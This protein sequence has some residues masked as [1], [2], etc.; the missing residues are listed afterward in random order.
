MQQ[1]STILQM[2]NRTSLEA[3]TSLRSSFFQTT[4]LGVYQTTPDGKIVAA[5]DA[6]INMLGYKSFEDLAD[7]NLN[8]Q[9]L[10][11]MYPRSQFIQMLEAQEEIVGLEYE[12]KKKDGTTLY[13]R[14]NARVIRN[15]DA[16][17]YYE[18][19]I[20]D[21]TDRKKG[22]VEITESKR[23]LQAEI[24]R[25]K[26][27]ANNLRQRAKQQRI[28]A[29]F[30]QRILISTNSTHIIDDALST[31][32]KAL[33][34]KHATYKQYLKK[35][36]KVIIANV[37]GF[38]KNVVDTVKLSV[39]KNSLSGYTLLSNAPVI[40]KDLAQEK[41]FHPPS[42]LADAKITSAMTVI[43]QSGKKIFG[44]LGVY[45]IN[46]RTFTRNDI[47]FIQ[48]IA[49]SLA[50]AMERDRID[51]ALR[52]SEERFRSI[53]DNALDPILI[54]DNKGRIS[55]ANQAL[56][57]L[58]GMDRDMLFSQSFTDLIIP[59]KKTKTVSKWKQFMQSGRQRGEAMIQR[60]DGTTRNIEYAAV[61][62]I[63]P[64][65]HLAMVRDITQ[66]KDEEQ[67]RD[68]FLG[69]ASHELKNALAS[70]KS[71]TQLL[72]RKLGKTD[73]KNIDYVKRI[74][75]NADRLKRLIDDLMDM[76][77]IKAG[78][79]ELVKEVFVFNQLLLETVEDFRNMAKSHVIVLDIGRD[80][81]VDGDKM[82]LRQ[83]LTN[84][85]KNAAKYSEPGNTILISAFKNK[86]H[87]K[88]AIQDQG[89]GISKKDQKKIFDLFYRAENADIARTT[90]MGVGLYISSEII[91]MHGGRM[92][93]E[94]KLKKGSTFSFTLPL[95][96]N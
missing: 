5:N 51:A 34:V 4:P 48:T 39:G 31:M 96:K 44:V 80:A 6:F 77:K 94:S 46:K 11:A 18:G 8:Q 56:I 90:G 50:S 54:L 45:S 61:A 47:S 37:F 65:Y 83:V 24:S 1:Y 30:G 21:I 40:V 23:K 43:V 2:K 53:F 14:E 88:I 85:L 35:E 49:N 78:R 13:V 25:R 17:I 69:I 64:H 72:E 93:V 9:H 32:T 28:A 26:L 20:E 67:R 42:F 62:N 63:V 22:E 59:E 7:V 82:R 29:K 57:E 81:L 15:D 68:H 89:I 79:L 66:T 76:T 70:V 75:A 91:K 58:T 41:R 60:A 10:G 19:T 52:K 3:L 55:N 73:E 92:G 36:N 84:L 74:D 16:H 87:I 95:A 12:W 27:V 38:P 33:D 71:F 86:T